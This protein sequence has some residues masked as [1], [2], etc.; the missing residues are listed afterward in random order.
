M[1]AEE[2]QRQAGP[3]SQLRGRELINLTS[4]DWVPGAKTTR[5]VFLMVCVDLPCCVDEKLGIREGRSLPK[6]TQP[7]M[8][9]MGNELISVTTHSLCS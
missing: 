8:A 5:I 3:P 1:G 6:V 9:G 7:K 4:T 2:P